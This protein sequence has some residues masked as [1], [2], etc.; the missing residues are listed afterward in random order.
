[1][2]VL[3]AV[4]EVILI[5]TL[6]YKNKTKRFPTGIHFFAFSFVTNF[7]FTQCYLPN[8]CIITGETSNNKK[9]Y[10]SHVLLHIFQ[11]ENVVSLAVSQ[12]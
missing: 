12:D 3:K 10:H 2:V 7:D 8:S 5:L 4:N 11:V 1:M 9:C 6:T